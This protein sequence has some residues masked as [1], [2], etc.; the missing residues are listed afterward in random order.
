MPNTWIQACNEYRT[1]TGITG[2][3]RK[4]TKEYDEIRSIQETLKGKSGK[5]ILKDTF[6]KGIDM[7]ARTVEKTVKPSKK[8]KPLDP[9]EHHSKKIGYEDGSLTYQNYNYLGPG[10]KVSKRLARGDMGI[11]NLDKA[12]KV[13]DVDYTYDLKKKY[14]E[15][16]LTKQ[17]V[18]NADD[19]FLKKVERYQHEDPLTAKVTKTAF[20]TKKI[21][22]DIG[23]LPISAFF[24]PATTGEGLGKSKPK[25]RPKK[26]AGIKL[27]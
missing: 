16:T 17:D 9:G 3:P 7:V 25:G 15:G 24:D 4:G 14:K 21:A 27:L 8:N 11:N 1:Q 26:G 18:R 20:K 19:R 13:H 23:L 2:V 12:A 6:E 5:G 22:E 10:T